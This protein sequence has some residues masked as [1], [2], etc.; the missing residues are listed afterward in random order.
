M[1]Y[2]LICVAEVKQDTHH[3]CLLK[4]YDI[5]SHTTTPPPPEEVVEATALER[6]TCGGAQHMDISIVFTR[7]CSFPLRIRAHNIRGV[8]THTQTS[9][10][11]KI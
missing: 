7:K 5:H 10:G 2:V 1:L 9:S 4:H 8:H 11:G 6:M 3:T